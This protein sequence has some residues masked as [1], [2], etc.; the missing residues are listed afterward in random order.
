MLS[1]FA[2]LSVFVGAASALFQMQSLNPAFA[3]AGTRGCIA[4]ASD[5]SGTPL[6]IHNCA[7]DDLSHQDWWF[8]ALNA[9]DRTQG[10]NIYGNM[11]H[12]AKHTFVPT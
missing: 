2:A 3:A 7:T 5:V 6:T 11:C 8:T 9:T 4:A 10:L 12:S 1:L